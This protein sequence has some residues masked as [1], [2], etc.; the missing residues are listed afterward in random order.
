MYNFLCQNVLMFPTHILFT[1]RTETFWRKDVTS[2]WD[3]STFSVNFSQK[4]RED[5][6]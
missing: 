3:I 1:K 6:F 4:I 2:M 5:K